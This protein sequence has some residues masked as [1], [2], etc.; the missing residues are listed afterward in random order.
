MHA[1]HTLRVNRQEHIYYCKNARTA[2]W[3]RAWPKLLSFETCPQRVG[4]YSNKE[5]KINFSHYIDVLQMQLLEEQPDYI[6]EKKAIYF[7][8]VELKRG[9]TSLPTC[10]VSLVLESQGE[11]LCVKDAHLYVS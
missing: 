2:F 11:F 9:T 4:P 10:S 5:I 1:H 6:H 8:N 7:Q 3:E